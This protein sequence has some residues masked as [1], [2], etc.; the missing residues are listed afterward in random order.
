MDAVWETARDFLSLESQ[1]NSRAGLCLRGRDDLSEEVISWGRRAKNEIL[2]IEDALQVAARSDVRTA[3]IRGTGNGR[4]RAL[5]AVGLHQS[6]NDGRFIWLPGLFALQG[7]C[8]VGDI[9]E[10]SGIE[11]VCTLDEVDLLVT[12]LVELDPWTRP[13]LRNGQATLLVEQKKRGWVILAKERI[14]E[15]SS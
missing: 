10:K 3:A 7:I 14:K 9:L 12:D 5:A 11:R 8:S 4:I 13:V 1:R 2:T 15:I 6:G